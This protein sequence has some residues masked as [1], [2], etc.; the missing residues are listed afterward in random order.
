MDK[1]WAKSKLTFDDET[2]AFN[3]SEIP[4]EKLWKKTL[5]LANPDTRKELL[6]LENV[7][8]NMLM[9]HAFMEGWKSGKVN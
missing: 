4:L 2:W 5:K 6:Q 3:N 1:S 8:K 9:I 7:I